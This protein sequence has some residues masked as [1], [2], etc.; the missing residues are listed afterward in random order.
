MECGINYH[1]MIKGAEQEWMSFVLPALDT[2][3]ARWGHYFTGFSELF[4]EQELVS[5]LLFL[6]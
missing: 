2:S 1:K 6:T 5:K 3:P 4:L